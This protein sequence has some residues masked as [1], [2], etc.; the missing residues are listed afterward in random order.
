MYTRAIV[1]TPCKAII[2]GLTTAN[3]GQ[4][5]YETALKQHSQYI[6]AL[7]KVGLEIIVLDPDDNF[8]DS[9]FVEDTAILTPP[10]AIITSPGAPSR[11]DDIVDIRQVLK[12]YFSH[13]ESVEAPGTIDGGDV[14]RTGSH[15]YIG[16]STRTNLAGA[17]QVIS[18]LNQYGM[19]G[20]TVA[21]TDVLH[22]K[23]GVSYLDDNN[24]VVSGE[25]IDSPEFK[26]FNLI[27]VAEDESYAANCIWINGLV[28]IAKGYS[29]TKRAIE[30]AGYRTLEM[31]VTEF[32]KIDGGLSCLSLRF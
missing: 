22:L 16:I 10:C 31:D 30:N 28:L 13:I 24:L 1:R 8:P 7:K 17:R 5:D 14:L 2:N 29:K 18:I 23:S 20:S 26:E 11:H 6:D 3:L 4:P 9:T 25:F 32:R 27:T 12:K 15:C 19:S 21:L